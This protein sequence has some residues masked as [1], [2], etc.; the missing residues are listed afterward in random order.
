MRFHFRTRQSGTI[1][2]I[3]SIGGLITFPLYSSYHATKWALEGFSEGLHYEVK[4]FGIHVCLVEPGTY[5]TEIFGR[6]KRIFYFIPQ[7]FHSRVCAA[8][9]DNTNYKVL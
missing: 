3:T 8:Y 4:P 2:N 1:I 5:P 7:L 6:N 9:C